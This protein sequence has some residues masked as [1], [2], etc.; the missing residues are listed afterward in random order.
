[1]SEAEAVEYFVE[2]VEAAVRKANLDVMVPNPSPDE[3]TASIYDILDDINSF[4][5]ETHFTLEN[6]ANMTDVRWKRLIVLGAAALCFDV[7]IAELTANGVDIQV[8]DFNLPS[9]LTDIS[10][11]RENWY[12]QFTTLLERLKISSQR[13]VR[14]KKYATRPAPTTSYNRL[15]KY[16]YSRMR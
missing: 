15:M 9:K 14:F 4:A 8:G 7:M 11:F 3:I 5:P 13:F 12:A 1:M 6:I 2:K 10:A 16:N